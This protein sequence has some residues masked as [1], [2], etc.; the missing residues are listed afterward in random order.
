MIRPFPVKE[1]EYSMESI[2]HTI[3]ES[4]VEVLH[5]LEPVVVVNSIANK[6]M[7]ERLLK[8]TTLLDRAHRWGQ[9]VVE[10]SDNGECETS[11]ESHISRRSQCTILCG[12]NNLETTMRPCPRE[13][14]QCL[15]VLPKLSCSCFEPEGG[16][17]KWSFICCKIRKI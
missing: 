11:R 9:E 5:I 10:F 2:R 12:T 1:I 17:F 13:N 15:L 7:K 3:P 4:A 8:H 6:F 14:L 16:K